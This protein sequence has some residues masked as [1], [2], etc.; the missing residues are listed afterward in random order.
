[1]P[2][3]LSELELSDLDFTDTVIMRGTETNEAADPAQRLLKQLDT[4]MDSIALKLEFGAGDP[5]LWRV[6]AGFY[7]ATERPQDYND[8]VRKHLEAFGHPLQLDQPAVSFV[9]P[10]K[11]NFDDIPKLDMIRTACAAPGG[12]VLDF[13]AVRRL[14]AGGLIALAEL[15]GALI[16]LAPQPQ[17]R[18]VDAFIA[19]IEGAVKSGQGTK[20]M[21]E[22]V[23]AYRRYA[24]AHPPRHGDERISAATG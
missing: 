3:K 6:L 2:A 11:V 15:F 23:N 10:V 12:A 22:M 17:L 13:S 9:L 5:R 24:R 1:M 16:P 20:D 4:I 21:Q 8:L 18:G 7:L 14:S 19:S